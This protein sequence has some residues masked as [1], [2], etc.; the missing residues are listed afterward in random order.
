MS[1]RFGVSPIAWINDDLPALG[2]GTPLESVLDD[3]RDVGFAGIE[4]GGKFPRDPN[5]LQPLLARHQLA[6]VGGWYSANLLTRS[7]AAEIQAMQSHLGLLKAMGCSVFIIAETS[8]AIHC[9][10]GSPMSATPRLADSAWDEFGRKLTDVGDYLV[11]AGLRVAYHHHLGTVVESQQDLD[12]FLKSTGRSVGLTVDTGHAALG[13]IDALALIRD[14]PLRIVHVHCKDIRRPVFKR[15]KSES[16]SFLSGVISGMFTVP[17]DGNLEFA[18]VMQALAKIG[19]AGWIIVEAEQDPA[20]AAPKTYAA[21]G[22]KTL[23]RE[24]TAANLHEMEN[25]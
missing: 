1:I 8:N 23:R 3:A 11:Q 15:V 2:R 24:A 17:G 12:R 16:K 10:Q 25:S 19:Y 5:E 13:G 20:V 22:L 18:G 6:L 4:L 7:A 21:L 14:H 9:D